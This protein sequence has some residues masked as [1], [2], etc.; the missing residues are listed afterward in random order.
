MDTGMSNDSVDRKRNVII[1]ILYLPLILIALSNIDV[2]IY[3]VKVHIMAAAV[4]SGCNI[5][6]MEKIN[7]IVL[8]S[9]CSWFIL[10]P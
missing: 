9:G 8:V 2:A 6:R 10:M 7:K 1:D 4:N 3:R 5:V